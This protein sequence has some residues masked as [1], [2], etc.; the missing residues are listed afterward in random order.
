MKGLETI[1]SA[2]TEYSAIGFAETKLKSI[3]DGCRKR[4]EDYYSYMRDVFT[5]KDDPAIQECEE[6]AFL[7]YLDEYKKC[8]EL[9]AGFIRNG[10]V[11]ILDLVEKVVFFLYRVDE[12]SHKSVVHYNP[13]KL[14]LIERSFPNRRFI[15]ELE[16]GTHDLSKD[17]SFLIK[18]CDELVTLSNII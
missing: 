3:A 11:F 12:Y 7:Q 15:R 10:K 8:C 9:Y 16:R 6:H 4:N 17:E 13:L 5:A 18:K 14:D 2:I 1:I